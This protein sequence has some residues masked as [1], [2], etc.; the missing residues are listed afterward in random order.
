MAVASNKPASQGARRGAAEPATDAAPAVPEFHKE[1]EL[2][3]YRD[4][5]LIDRP[6]TDDAPA[7]AAA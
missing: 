1:Q 4:M 2:Q 7:I 3:A 5:L 6:G